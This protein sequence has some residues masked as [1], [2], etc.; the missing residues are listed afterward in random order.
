MPATQPNENN[1]SIT[2]GL[3]ANAGMLRLLN[4][5]SGAASFVS[6]PIDLSS[7]NTGADPSIEISTVGTL[8]GTFTLELSNSYDPGT[9]P[10][11]TFLLLADAQTAPSLAGSNPAGAGTQYLGSF[12]HTANRGAAKWARLRW[13]FVS[14][15]GTIDAWFFLRGVAR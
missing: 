12:I 6:S 8:T 5:Q 2:M 4:A 1:Q 13:A 11:A 3:Q 10:G 14:G 7:L 9:N 15:A